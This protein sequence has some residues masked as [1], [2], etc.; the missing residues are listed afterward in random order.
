[1]MTAED[2]QI[3]QFNN[4]V[5]NM[6]EGQFAS[7]GP[8]YQGVVLDIKYPTLHHYEEGNISQEQFETALEAISLLSKITGLELEDTSQAGQ[9]GNGEITLADI[10]ATGIFLNAEMPDDM[11]VGLFNGDY[12]EIM[13]NTA[14]E[15]MDI[16][17]QINEMGDGAFDVTEM[18]EGIDD[19]TEAIHNFVHNNDTQ[20]GGGIMKEP[21]EGG[22]VMQEPTQQGGGIMQEL[23]DLPQTNGDQVG[24]F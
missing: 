1:M 18:L 15:A 10:G 13:L 3:D 11:I 19:V 9:G 22:G 17:L 24:G 7:F 4:I 6:T 5:Q 23:V 16:L 20:V 12:Q 21:V 2:G 14:E 8:D